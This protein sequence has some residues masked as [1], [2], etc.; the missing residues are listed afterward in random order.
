MLVGRGR[1]RTLVE[2]GSTSTGGGT[3]MGVMSSASPAT[4][5][6]S[7]HWCALSWTKNLEMLAGSDKSTTASSPAKKVLKK[8]PWDGKKGG[9]EGG[10]GWAGGLAWP[11]GSGG[12]VAQWAAASWLGNRRRY[13]VQGRSRCVRKSSDDEGEG[14][15]RTNTR[16]AAATDAERVERKRDGGRGRERDVEGE[17]GDADMEAG[18]RVPQ[19]LDHAA[20]NG[21]ARQHTAAHGSARQRTAAHRREQPQRSKMGNGR[22]G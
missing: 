10:C 14:P 9:G 1:E 19:D 6:P 20:A 3:V 7:A 16:R 18:R 21:G 11:A 13:K 8:K 15:S 17:G 2:R 4:G 22:D 12:E 5:T